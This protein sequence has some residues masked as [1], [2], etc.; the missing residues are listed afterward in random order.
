MH[1]VHAGADPGQKP[2]DIGVAGA[3]SISIGAKRVR[4]IGMVAVAHQLLLAL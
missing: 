2:R 1:D 4:R 3:F